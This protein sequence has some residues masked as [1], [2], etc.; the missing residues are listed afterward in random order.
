MSFTVLLMSAWQAEA[1]QPRNASPPGDLNTCVLCH[2]MPEFWSEEQQRLYVPKEGLASD[3]HYRQGVKCYECHGGDPTSLNVTQAHANMRLRSGELSASEMTKACGR[4]HEA[5]FNGLGQSVHRQVVTADGQDTG[6]IECRS[7]HTDKL[8]QILPVADPKSPVYRRNQLQICGD[9]HTEELNEYAE[10][11]HGHGLLKS[12]LPSA[13]CAD[14]H[15]AHGVYR[16]SDERSTLHPSNAADTCASC[17]RLI[18]E[19]LERSVHGSSFTSEGNVSGIAPGGQSTRKPGCTDCHV[20]HDLPYADTGKFRRGQGD[21]CGKCHAELQTTYRLS[22]HGELSDLGYMAGAVCSDCHGAHDI[23]PLSDP[24]SKMS[25]ENRIDTCAECHPGIV[26]NLATFDP[27]ANHHDPERS[28]LV[29]WVYRGV[30]T[31]IICVFG[32]FG[33]HSV[34]WFIRSVLDVRSHGRPPALSPRMPSF[35]RFN[36]FHRIAHSVMVVS[37]LGLALTGLPLK[38][39]SYTWAQW[40]AAVLGGFTWTGF[41]HRFFSI[42]TFGCFGAYVIYLLRCFILK[43]REGA[44]L[45]EAVFGPDSPVPNPRDARDMFAM[46]KWFVGLG[47]R[48]SF[49]RWA[50]WEKFDFFGASSD[51]ILI[52]TTGLVL[53]FPNFFC[54]F[55]PGEAVNIAKVVHTTLALLATGFVFA[56]HF[57]GTHFRPDKFPMDMSILTGVVSE[58]E[59]EHE[60]PELLA[61]M[62]REGRIE[63][64]RAEAPDRMKLWLVRLAG[65]VALFL[66]L[67]SLAGIIWSLLL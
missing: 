11:G 38:F 54:L 14:C 18:E 51:I 61:R 22:M 40:L 56:I 66:G 28:Q 29:F 24:D 21:R 16:A 63:E 44:S 48:P 8:H 58:T 43:R 49:E 57:F 55:L 1:E 19:R 25:M 26:T 64:L 10:S 33:T 32:F 9:C 41:W 3:V 34:F 47:P 65:F 50:Y 36:S 2:G 20:G 30:L 37:F 59:M 23:L 4:C 6:L 46:G 12:G 60:R 53:W 42:T 62:E 13:S 5:Q 31:F 39:S 27:H 17:H 45:L 7:C 15:G 35:T 67:G 52:G